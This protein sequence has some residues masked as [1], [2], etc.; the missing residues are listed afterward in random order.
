MSRN[1]KIEAILA[2]WFELQRCVPFE[3]A[4]AERTFNNLLD[5][6]IDEAEK[7]GTPLTREDL[8]DYLYS[9]LKEYRRT[10][11]ANEKLENRSSTTDEPTAL[12]TATA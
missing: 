11:V 7:Q 3:R 4:A 10:R 1:P 6:V 9:H 2:A 12:G 8:K 5:D